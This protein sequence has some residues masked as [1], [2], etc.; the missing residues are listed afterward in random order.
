MAKKTQIQKFRDTAREAGGDESKER[1]NST[2]KGLAKTPR[3]PA[4]PATIA[5]S[6]EG[7]K[8]KH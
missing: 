6:G 3:K 2:L 4:Q 7:A 5:S 1:F 8:P